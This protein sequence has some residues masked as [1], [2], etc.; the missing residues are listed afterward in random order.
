MSHLHRIDG[1]ASPAAPFDF[2]KTLDFLRRFPPTFGLNMVV[3]N[4]VH[5]AQ[6]INGRTVLFRISARGTVQQPFLHYTVDLHKAQDL[7]E[8]EKEAIEWL[9]FFLGWDDDLHEFYELAEHDP[10]FAPI[11]RAL[12]GYHHVKFPS[13][14][15]A[16]VWAIVS[17][18]NQATVARGMH[19]AL[20]KGLATEFHGMAWI[21]GPFRKPRKWPRWRYPTCLPAYGPCVAESTYWMPPGPLPPLTPHF[22]VPGRSTLWKT[23]CEGLRALVPGRRASSFFAP[24]AAPMY[25]QR[26]IGSL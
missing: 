22:C 18:R 17:Q 15:E 24:W 8:A 16:A 3:G 13:P 14:F 2:A 5:K 21:T 12:Y 4:C 25:I 19:Q 10:Y 11:A 23:G 1:T 20:L 26:T 7:A 9:R 6:R